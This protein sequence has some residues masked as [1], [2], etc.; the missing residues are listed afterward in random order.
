LTC[1]VFSVGVGAELALDSG[2]ITSRQRQVTALDTEEQA[3]RQQ[4][5]GQARV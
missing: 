5:Q 3:L 1:K 2:G 4:R